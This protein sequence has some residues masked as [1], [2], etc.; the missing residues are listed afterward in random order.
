MK[1]LW[2]MAC[3]LAGCSE[4]GTSG[5]AGADAA[6][7][8]DA[9]SIDASRLDAGRDA[10]A[11]AA[12]PPADAGSA[13]DATATDA[14]GACAPM[15]VMEG[16]PCGPTER[17]ARRYRWNGTSCEEIAW[18]RCVGTD[19]DGLFGS[20][21]A[22]QRA[23]A[24]CIPGGCATDADCAEGA[25]W[26]VEGSCVPCDNGGLACRIAC[27]AGW[28]VYTRNGCTPCECAPAN[29]CTSD[30]DCAGTEGRPQRCHAGAFCWDW[31]PWGDPSC[32]YGNVCAPADCPAPP[33]LCARRGCPQ[34]QTCEFGAS[35][36]PTTCTCNDAGEWACTD[37]C[38]GGACVPLPT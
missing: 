36:E 3:V 18:C 15:D 26:C 20:R 9:A 35:C 30:A 24:R 2:V 10:A 14:G 37:D 21:G 17:P 12:A 1:R 13:L 7:S 31:C 25:E 27:P 5:D 8:R 29:D 38:G 4:A 34:G 19:C 22:C 32:C 6:A 11:E 16:E 23:Y 28:S 33:P